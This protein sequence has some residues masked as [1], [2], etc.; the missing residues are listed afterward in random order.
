MAITLLELKRNKR[1]KILEI[2]GGSSLVK[3]LEALGIRVGVKVTKINGTS[4]PVVIKV[5][6]TQLAIGKGMAS[7]IIV[8]EQ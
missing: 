3:K 7:K 2:K 5:V 4:S 8:E 6:R 1:G